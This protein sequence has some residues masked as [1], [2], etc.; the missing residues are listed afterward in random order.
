MIMP[1]C[2]AWRAVAAPM[3][4]EAPVMMMTRLARLCFMVV[5]YQRK[6]ILAAGCG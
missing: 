2:A 6:G 5:V 4:D 1:C 3:P